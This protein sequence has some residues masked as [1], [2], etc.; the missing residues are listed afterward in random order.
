MTTTPYT[1]VLFTDMV[2]ST[3]ARRS[4]RNDHLKATKQALLEFA[5]A[6]RTVE[7]Q[8]VRQT[9]DELKAEFFEPWLAIQAALHLQVVSAA[10]RDDLAERIGLDIGVYD[11]L[12]SVDA[13]YY[14]TVARAQRIMDVCPGKYILCSSSV[15]EG[16]TL[17]QKKRLVVFGPSYV[18]LRGFSRPITIYFI[19]SRPSFDEFITWQTKALPN[20]RSTIALLSAGEVSEV[21]AN[22]S[23]GAITRILRNKGNYY[24][25]RRVLFHLAYFCFIV[26]YN[27]GK[28][29]KN[30]VRFSLLGAISAADTAMLLRRSD[31]SLK[32]IKVI[33]KINSSVQDA[34]YWAFWEYQIGHCLAHNNPSEEA[35]RY[36]RRAYARA[37]RLGNAW[38]AGWTAMYLGRC[39]RGRGFYDEAEDWLLS[40]LIIL[41]YSNKAVRHSAYALAQLIRLSAV[42]GKY[43]DAARYVEF[44][45]ELPEEAKE[46]LDGK[47]DAIW[48]TRLKAI[49]S[50]EESNTKPEYNTLSINTLSIVDSIIDPLKNKEGGHSWLKPKKY[51]LLRRLAIFRDK[52][53]R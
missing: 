47:D 50:N 48:E 2:G 40:S 3:S 51:Q 39:L 16:L 43:L 36:L 22:L 24:D 11:E 49:L 29:H 14:R 42:Q 41:S 31:T 17:E 32:W 4:V 9:G 13:D 52:L 5:H 12:T 6:I 38:L 37:E 8:Q 10:C 30:L 53:A 28:F 27:I 20:A 34:F 18:R 46:A 15:V 23:T 33:E 1:C 35:E 45:G 7:G 25:F 21:L 26:I 44:I 19:N